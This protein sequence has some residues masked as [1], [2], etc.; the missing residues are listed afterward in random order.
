MSVESEKAL[1][2][3]MIRMYCRGMHAEPPGDDGLCEACSRLA[4]YAARRL[5][6]CR[7]GD[8]KPS[9]RA[10]ATHC[11]APREREAIRQVMRY[12]GPRLLFL[13]PLQ[14]V[15]HYILKR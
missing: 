5:D 3:R 6:M 14:M 4:D 8:A 1:V 15:R 12:A 2:A 11:Y 9:C 7:Y 10:C 13:A